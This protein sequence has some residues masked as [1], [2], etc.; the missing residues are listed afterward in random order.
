MLQLLDHTPQVT[1]DNDAL[2]AF[3]I[4]GEFKREPS[5]A[6]RIDCFV[7]LRMR[8]S[9]GCGPLMARAGNGTRDRRDIL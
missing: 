1:S 4:S 8:D 5:P 6:R 7:I 2:T 3:Q 9:D